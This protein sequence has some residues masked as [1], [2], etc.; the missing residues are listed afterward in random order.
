MTENDVQI[1]GL[2]FVRFV[3]MVKATWHVM[4]VL[5]GGGAWVIVTYMNLTTQVKTNSAAIA[6]TRT[7]SQA[8]VE[9]MHRDSKAEMDAIIEYLDQD[10]SAQ[11]WM[12]K[13]FPAY[14]NGNVPDLPDLPRD[15]LEREKVRPQSQS[16]PRV[17]T[18][19]DEQ[20]QQGGLSDFVP[21]Q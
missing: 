14:K 13:Q 1:K 3:E 7:D 2:T 18:S 5:A 17:I 16:Y 21:T 6:Q 12:M 9:Q 19:D 20:Q 10:R 15:P 11:R 4:I 8:A